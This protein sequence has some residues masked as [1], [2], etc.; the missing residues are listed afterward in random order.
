MPPESY[1]I[2]IAAL[3][4]AARQLGALAGS[5]RAEGLRVGDCV[6]V[7]AAAAPG[8]ALADELP[9]LGLEQL[10]GTLSARCRTSADRTAAA[11][12]GYRVMEVA[13]QGVFTPAGGSGVVAR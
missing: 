3:D 5:V 7:L 13:L 1:A 11:A 6:R 9:G 12:E 8:S 10:A 2:Q 4:E